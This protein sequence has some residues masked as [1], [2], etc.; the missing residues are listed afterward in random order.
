MKNTLDQ[1]AQ[2]YKKI[3]IFYSV[4]I[5]ITKEWKGFVGY[6][7]EDKVK[8]SMPTDI[9]NTLFLSCG[10]DILCNNSEKIWK[11]LGVIN[12]QIFRF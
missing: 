11:G 3:N 12:A 2:K 10:P 7:D 6:I 8:K 5:A 1:Y 9:K 4:D